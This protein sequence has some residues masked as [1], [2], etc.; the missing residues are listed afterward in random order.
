MIITQKYIS[1]H[2]LQ[3]WTCV[4]ASSIPITQNIS[5]FKG[6]DVQM[7]EMGL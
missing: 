5:G 4:V 6:V 1:N 3:F 7:S 2:F